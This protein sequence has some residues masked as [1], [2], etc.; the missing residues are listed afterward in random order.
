MS[1][2]D[3][4]CYFKKIG[5]SDRITEHELT[6]DTVEHAAEIIGCTPAEIAKTL[7]FLVNEKPVMVVMAGDARVNSSKFK[8]IFHQKPIM[9]PRENVEQQIGHKPGGVCPFAVNEAVAIYL[10]ISMKRFEKV[11]TAG[12]IDTATLWVSIAE[13]EKYSGAIEWV[14]VCKGWYINDEKL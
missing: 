1:Y 4:K 11:Y 13:L 12:G 10:D 6:G 9:M 5:L 2:E 14:D 7:S 8:A 3:V